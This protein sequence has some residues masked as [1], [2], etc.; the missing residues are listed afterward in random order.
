M[1]LQPELAQAFSLD[2]KVA[3]ITGAA[4]G[5]GREAA[6]IFALAGARLW[7]ADVDEAGLAETARIAADAGGAASCHRVDVTS[8]AEMEALA[9]T[10]AAQTGRLDVW[11]NCAGISFLHSILETQVEQAEKTVAVNMMGVYWG[12]MAAGRVMKQLGG[13]SIINIASAGGAMP[14][15]S[16]AVYGMTKA[17]VISLSWT[18]AAEFGPYGI[19][20]NA[21]A[22]GW[23]ET[24]MAEVLYRDAEGRIDQDTRGKVLAEMASQS[25]LGR[26]GRPIDIAHAMLYLASDAGSFVTGQML[27]VNGGASMG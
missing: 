16:L 3:V 17:G 5:M 20:V 19:R 4:S 26:T 10:A 8:K 15:P 22:P 6:R 24:P 27:R 14:V 18:A 12:C 11:V 25:P 2:G 21:I 7:L 9:D 23:T 1:A 13:G